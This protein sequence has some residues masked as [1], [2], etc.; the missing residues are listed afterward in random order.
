MEVVL[1]VFFFTALLFGFIYCLCKL[2]EKQKI[3][4]EQNELHKAVFE[5]LSF[6]GDMLSAMKTLINETNAAPEPEKSKESSAQG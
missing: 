6:D 4:C 3:R 2:D 1:W 5:K